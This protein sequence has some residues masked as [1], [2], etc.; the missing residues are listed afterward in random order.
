MNTSG[1]PRAN[2]L[3]AAL[4]DAAYRRLL[5]HLEATTLLAGRTLFRPS[6][7]LECAYFPTNSAVTLSY[8]LGGTGTIAAAS[9][10]GREGMVGISLFLG[11]PQRDNRADVEFGGLAFRLPA[12]TLRA[13]FKRA[14]ALQR[15]VLRY[16]FALMAQASQLGLCNQYHPLERRLCGFLSRAFDRVAADELVVTQSRIAEFLGVRRATV[17][18]AAGHLQSA[19]II[20]CVRGRV[21]LISRKK[22]EKRA[23]ACNAIIRRAF[24]A[25]TT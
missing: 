9:P 13:E 11:S 8:A 15:V 24:E 3:L 5:P 25:V 1:T 14:Q 21:V 20:E 23:C 4:P 19:G 6:D 12:S 17:T 10:I 18:V 7:R 22:L 2:R 16:V